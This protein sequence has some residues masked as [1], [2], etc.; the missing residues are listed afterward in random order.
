MGL[1]HPLFILIPMSEQLILIESPRSWRLDERTREIGIR[2][3]IG[4][5]QR[6]ILMQFLFESALICL[7]GGLLGIGISMLLTMAVNSTGAFTASLSPGIMVSAVV[8]AALV[9]II[10]GLVP[11]YKGARFAPIDALRYE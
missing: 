10:A 5:R 4:A 6:S 2:K 3:A 8:I 9:G 7:V 1:S 11:A